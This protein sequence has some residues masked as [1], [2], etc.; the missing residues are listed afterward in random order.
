VSDGGK[1]I[2][3]NLSAYVKLADTAR[4]AE[5]KQFHDY[6]VRPVL[7]PGQPAAQADHSADARVEWEKKHR[8]A[9]EHRLTGINPVPC[10]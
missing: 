1:H 3:I 4:Y 6:P 10:I 7:R 9:D 5:V 2:V 8:R